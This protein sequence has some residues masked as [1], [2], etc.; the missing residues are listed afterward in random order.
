MK[1]KAKLIFGVVFSLSI[2]A[3]TVAVFYIMKG[4]KFGGDSLEGAI[5]L[6]SENNKFFND[7]KIDYIDRDNHFVV[8]ITS[9]SITFIPVRFI[10]ENLGYTV[11]Y[12]ADKGQVVLTREGNVIVAKVGSNEVIHNGVPVKIDGANPDAV[13]MNLNGRVYL[14]LRLFAEILDKK[15]VFDRGL[16]FIGDNVDK[17]SKSEDYE[18]RITQIISELGI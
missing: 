13:V 10:A 8:P 11:N 6:T 1:N 4:N 3:A 7:G 15:V 18:Q 9:F 2:I 14:P 5:I 16:L 12:D 17:F